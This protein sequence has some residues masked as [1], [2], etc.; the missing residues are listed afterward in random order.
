MIV[1]IITVE[2]TLM[3]VTRY[4]PV[5][6]SRMRRFVMGSGFRCTLGSVR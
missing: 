3:I 1:R 5:S 6:G 2:I 4:R